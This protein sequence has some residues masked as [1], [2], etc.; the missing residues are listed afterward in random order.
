VTPSGLHDEVSR[1]VLVSK[2]STPDRGLSDRAIHAI[3]A[4]GS[5]A[6]R[7]RES[8][9]EELIYGQGVRAFGNR[10]RLRSG[11]RDFRG[12]LLDESQPIGKRQATNR[13]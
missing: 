11:L 4:N 2:A 9:R 3:Q 10:G 6:R 7:R 13:R 5:D 8:S 12:R 1:E